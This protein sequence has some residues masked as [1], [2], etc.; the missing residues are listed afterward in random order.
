MSPL[1]EKLALMEKCRL[2]LVNKLKAERMHSKEQISELTAA[3][4]TLRTQC[5]E[6][7]ASE[8]EMYVVAD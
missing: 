5:E 3:L 7:T 1:E 6:I 8:K 4:A 2:E